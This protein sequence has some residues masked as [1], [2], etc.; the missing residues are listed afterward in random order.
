MEPY[1]LSQDMSEGAAGTR[2]RPIRVIPLDEKETRFQLE[3]RD[4]DGEEEKRS[5]CFLPLDDKTQSGYQPGEE[6][7]ADVS[8]K[9][10]H[11]EN[12]ETTLVEDNDEES[13]TDYW[14]ESFEVLGSGPKLPL[15]ENPLPT[16]VACCLTRLSNPFQF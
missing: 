8:E 12:V 3:E 5:K 4:E 16:G 14:K 2:L 6:R 13:R 10:F 15:L 11:L 9:D 1:S 7:R